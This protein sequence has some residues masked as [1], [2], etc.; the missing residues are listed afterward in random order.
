[1]YKKRPISSSTTN[2]RKKNILFSRQ[3]SLETFNNQSTNRI[4][5]RRFRK[6]EKPTR[7]SSSTTSF[8]SQKLNFKNEQTN[9]FNLL[10]LMI[11]SNPNKFNNKKLKNKIRYINNLY[12]S[13]TKESYLLP[14]STKRVKELFYNYNVLYGQ[15]TSNLIRTYSPTM[16]PKSSSVN[17]FVKKMNMIQKESLSVFSDNEILDL[18]KA[19]C[20]DIGIDVKEHMLSKFKDYCNS[21]CKN[22]IVDL[23]ENYL[24]LNSVKFLGNILYNGERIARLNL[25]KNNLGDIGAEL[26]VNSIKNS[27]SLIS[28]NISSNGITC[29]GGEAVFKRMIHQQSLLDFNISTLEGSKNRNRL[30]SL[31]IKDIFL[32]LKNNFLIE[33]LNISGNSLKNEGFILLCKGLNENQSLNSLKIA[34]NEIEEKGIIQGLKYIKIIIPKLSVLDISKNKIMDQGLIILTDQLKFFPNLFSLNIS[35]CSFEFKG[36]EYLMKNLQYSRKV[37]ILNV[38]GNRLK[39]K[40]FDTLKSYFSF[41]GLRTLNMSKCYLCDESAYELGLCIEQNVTIKKLNISENEI[42]DYGF[43]SFSTLFYKNYIMEYFD[44]SS[45]FITDS[46]VKDL[47]KSLEVNTTL[48]SINLYDNQLHNEIGN[49]IVEVLETNKTLVFINLFYNRIQMKKIDEINKILKYNAENQKQKRVPNLIRSVKDLEFNPDQFRLLT[50]KIKERKREQNYLYQKVKQEDKV[51]TSVI[52]EH[53]KE[54][55]IKIKTLNN[56]KKQINNIENNIR[57]IEKE[58]DSKEKEF[59]ASEN[60]YKDKIF[61]EQNILSEIIA[62]KTTL[63]N[64]YENIKSENS[65]VLALT[66]EKY[67]LSYKAL[68]KLENSL[69]RIKSELLEKK[70]IYQNLMKINIFR[71][72]NKMK[73][74][75]SL[76]TNSYANSSKSRSRSTFRVNRNSANINATRIAGKKIFSLDKDNKLDLASINEEIKKKKTKKGNNFRRMKSDN[77]ALLYFSKKKEN[78]SNILKDND[79]I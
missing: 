48:K 17:R 11:K 1:M 63:E 21:K 39:S 72:T 3:F 12:T 5:S 69:N 61:E 38:S 49:L 18:I 57:G 35:F 44:C 74:A 6:G 31:G 37:E 40:S 30:T 60:N 66:K 70:Q 10:N 58:I 7:P 53:Q 75:M 27:N 59:V 4:S 77:M 19:K 8:F 55:N 56:I 23:T 2:R 54:I 29:K 76:N 79:E 33:F 36:F 64:E 46:G 47:I 15:N 52:E 13:N 51:F 28:L 42:T 41:I 73:T 9:N 65:Q 78:D 25:S 16:R 20:S 34:Q 24:G 32:Y 43:K 68:K 22:R 62:N 67:N 26:L 14:K 71:N 50:K 45:N